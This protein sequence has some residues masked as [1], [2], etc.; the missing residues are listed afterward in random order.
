MF[1]KF[2]EWTQILDKKKDFKL[3]PGFLSFFYEKDVVS[4]GYFSY[5]F[6]RCYMEYAH[7][8]ILNKLIFVNSEGEN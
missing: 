7:V 5:V 3:L 6:I 2:E 4:N 8:N 1:S